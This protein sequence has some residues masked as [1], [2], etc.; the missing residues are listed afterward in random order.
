MY[1]QPMS[2]DSVDWRITGTRTQAHNTNRRHRYNHVGV[3]I[4]ERKSVGGRT[5]HHVFRRALMAAVIHRDV[6]IDLI[7]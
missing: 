6:I 4:F 2:S 5:S 1:C 7:R 3:V